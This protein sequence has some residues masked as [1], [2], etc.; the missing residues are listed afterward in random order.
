MKKF[1]FLAMVLILCASLCACSRI[2]G[3]E[4]AA[5][6]PDI[7]GQWGTDYFGEAFVLSLQADGSCVILENPG[8]WKL[9]TKQSDDHHVILNV[10]TEQAKYFV[11]LGRFLPEPDVS[12]T[13]HLLI[14]D[15]KQEITV[16]T[17]PVFLAGEQFVYYEEALHSV[18]EL[19]GEWGSK[20]W[21]EESTLTIREDG[22]CTLLRQ[23]GRWCLRRSASSWPEVD[24][25]IKLD[26]GEQFSSKFWFEPTSLTGCLEIYS[27]ST[28]TLV[29]PSDAAAYYDPIVIN[30]T[31]VPSTAEIIPEAVGVWADVTKPSVPIVSFNEDGTCEILGSSGVWSFECDIYPNSLLYDL[32]VDSGKLTAIINDNPYNINF[33]TYEDGR[34]DITIFNRDMAIVP[35]NTEIIH[36]AEN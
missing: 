2:D 10:Q 34:H 20:Y 36:I 7:V 5:L 11:D 21:K 30:R 35:H 1:I 27:D 22:T 6:Y 18:P 32:P 23:P 3:A 17:G 28:G 9:D 13:V 19:I 4:A 12:E 33:N 16:Y 26:S 31:I 15:Q 25:L 14:M 8:T 29:Y 24:I